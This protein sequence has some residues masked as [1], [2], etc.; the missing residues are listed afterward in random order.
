MKTDI[1]C[2]QGNKTIRWL[3]DAATIWYIETNNTQLKKQKITSASVKV[4]KNT[5]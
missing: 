1:H 3:A 5:G 4:M 2:G